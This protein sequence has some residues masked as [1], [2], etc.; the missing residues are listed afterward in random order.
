MPCYHEW[1][2]MQSGSKMC[3][4]CGRYE[5]EAGPWTAI[6]SNSITYDQ[7]RDIYQ[8]VK[9]IDLQ[10][11]EWPKKKTLGELER[12]LEELGLAPLTN[13]EEISLTRTKKKPEKEPEVQPLGQKR[14]FR[15]L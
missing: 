11:V 8:A 4:R 14:R 15:P 5:S 6:S 10:K 3:R 13:W 1:L 9:P 2:Y 7:F 12:E